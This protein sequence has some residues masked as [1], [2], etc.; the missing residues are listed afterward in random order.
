MCVYV[1]VC[2]CVC[3]C[4]CTFVF[5]YVQECTSSFLWYLQIGM[6]PISQTAV[7]LSSQLLFND[8]TAT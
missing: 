7:S 3:A 1:C 2:V 4:V 8:L 5:L 6:G